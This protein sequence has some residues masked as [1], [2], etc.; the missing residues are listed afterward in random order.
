MFLSWVPDR[1]W[2]QFLR[3]MPEI[4]ILYAHV[5][6]DVSLGDTH[7][8]GEFVRFLTNAEHAI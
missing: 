1:V 4:P 8:D 2:N 3:D 7:E 6:N 5:T